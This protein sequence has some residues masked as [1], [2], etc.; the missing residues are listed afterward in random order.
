[1]SLDAFIPEIW[2]GKILVNLKNQLVFANPAIINSDYSGDLVSYGDTVHINSV[3]AV[4]VGTYTKNKLDIVPQILT[5]SS[6]AFVIDQAD[7]FAFMV[8]DVDTAQQNP[9]VM[10]AAMREA[11]FALTNK[12]DSYVRDL[13]VNGT[14]GAT[15]GTG[16]WLAN[17][18]AT[19]ST[20]WNALYEAFVD[21]SV[22]L[23]ENNAPDDGRFAIINPGH[24]GERVEA[25]RPQGGF[26]DAVKGLHVYGGKV[27]RPEL[28]AKVAVDL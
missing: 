25:Y 3:G 18:T 21:L 1:M 27:I 26:E 4:T 12:V 9:K 17:V 14:A 11:A 5:D 13:I 23:D 8:D 7:Y 22:V 16:N 6:Q 28:L 15:A 20:T 2:H 24:H 19:S 10:A